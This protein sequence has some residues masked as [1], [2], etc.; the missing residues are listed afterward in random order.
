MSKVVFEY[1][2]IASALQ[3]QVKSAYQE[4]VVSESI[5][6][7]SISFHDLRVQTHPRKQR[8]GGLIPLDLLLFDTSGRCGREEG[9]RARS[10]AAHGIT[11]GRSLCFDVGVQNAWNKYVCP[12]GVPQ[13]KR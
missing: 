6:H 3:S 8:F 5:D 13:W 9:L 7:V 12:G 11:I 4:N 1:V 2:M 10:D